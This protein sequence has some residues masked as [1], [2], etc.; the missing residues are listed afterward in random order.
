METG[1][2]GRDPGPHGGVVIDQA[3]ALS[4]GGHNSVANAALLCTVRETMLPEL[5]H[6]A[7][8][9]QWQGG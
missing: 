6:S 1:R 4:G 7:S 2:A 9:L 8:R 5:R 3:P